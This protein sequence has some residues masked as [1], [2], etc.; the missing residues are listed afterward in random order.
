MREHDHAVLGKVNVGLDGVHASGDGAPER[1]HGVLRELSL[2][3]AVPDG[4]RERP[5]HGD[6]ARGGEGGLHG[7]PWAGGGRGLPSGKAC[8]DGPWAARRGS[9]SPASRPA[10]PVALLMFGL[11]KSEIR[12][13]RSS[14]D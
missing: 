3:A 4:L 9:L 1:R 2:V 12:V 14:L 11:L 8:E 7:Q 5:L 6:G 10:L 13:V